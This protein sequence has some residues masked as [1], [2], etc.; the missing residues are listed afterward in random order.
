MKTSRVL[1][2]V[3]AGCGLA[4]A[5]LS[6]QTPVPP[7]AAPRSV[8]ATPARPTPVDR[9]GHDRIEA[10]RIKAARLKA[11]RIHAAREDAANNHTTRRDLV[12]RRTGGRD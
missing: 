4:A 10:A 6:A 8:I 1:V 9:P 12:R 2:L 7:A 5:N 11:A 3:F